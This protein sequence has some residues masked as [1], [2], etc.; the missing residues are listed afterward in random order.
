MY[1]MSIDEADDHAMHIKGKKW[2]QLS[3][4]DKS[5]VMRKLQISS[6]TIVYD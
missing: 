1:Y 5:E 4:K 2:N 6:W 3:N